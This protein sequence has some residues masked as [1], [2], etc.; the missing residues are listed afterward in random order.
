MT[1]TDAYLLE[2]YMHSLVS[3]S[4]EI[5]ASKLAGSQQRSSM[6][7]SHE[8]L[9]ALK[10]LQPAFESRNRI[11]EFT[12]FLRAKST[13]RMDRALLESLIAA[14]SSALLSLVEL[15][16]SISASKPSLSAVRFANIQLADELFVLCGVCNV[17]QALYTKV[18]KPSAFEILRAVDRFIVSSGEGEVEKNE[19]HAEAHFESVNRIKLALE[20][21]S[22]KILSE[23]ML[24]GSL[25]VAEQD[26]FV[27]PQRDNR[28]ALS[29]GER[30]QPKSEQRLMETGYMSRQSFES[31]SSAYVELSEVPEPLK[32]H[33]EAILEAGAS[34]QCVRSMRQGPRGKVNS[35][36]TQRHRH[37]THSSSSLSFRFDDPLIMSTLIS[38]Q[39]E[40][41]RAALL[42][43]F[44]ASGV[45]VLESS[46]NCVFDYALFRK[47]DWISEKLDFEG[48]SSDATS[49][50]LK[51]C[52][53][54]GV[55]LVKKPQILT[56]AAS[57]D[58]GST[59]TSTT[60][61][62]SSLSVRCRNACE[63]FPAKIVFGNQATVALLSEISGA[64]IQGR[65]VERSLHLLWQSMQNFSKKYLSKLNHPAN[66]SKSLILLNRMIAQVAD[67]ISYTSYHLVE[68]AYQ[69]LLQ[70]V[71]RN[72]SVPTVS[73][74]FQQK[75]ALIHSA[76][77]QV[78]STSLPRKTLKDEKLFS[79]CLL[80]TGNMVKILTLLRT[81]A[82][83]HQAGN[84]DFADPG[85][86]AS[87]VDE[88]DQFIQSSKF[89]NMV[90]R[91]EDALGN[92]TKK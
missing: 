35:N 89:S 39:L 88:I 76:T 69:D 23:W 37:Q 77:F 91:F 4:N 22:A 26:F 44:T 6:S 2:A 24:E 7:M 54:D 78:D 32:R 20:S 51:V 73:V 48:Q 14:E 5:F 66:F 40:K 13:G 74:L 52:P 72:D 92:V 53:E 27:K 8:Q 84:S 68:P 46:L 33:S 49:A 28:K 25:P 1:V 43:S 47:S 12:E 16:G 15:E 30:T 65:H 87:A 10:C 56:S 61:L 31:L 21:E 71:R 9:E 86:S 11:V 82:L 59:G 19:S 42:D 75:I 90:T 34:V 64:L 83:A 17:L 62:F 50:F 18:G 80:Y 57:L 70:A 60:S 36:I 38:Q 29:A 81:Q 55:E 41:S 79:T 3:G 63:T 58:A 67:R 85:A 45:N